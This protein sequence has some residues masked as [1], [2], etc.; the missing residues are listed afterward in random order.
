ML[1]LDVTFY[2]NRKNYYENLVI[3]M[4]LQDHYYYLVHIQK[5]FEKTV[6]WAT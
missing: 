5:I 4:N 6:Y 2:N 3:Y 1:N